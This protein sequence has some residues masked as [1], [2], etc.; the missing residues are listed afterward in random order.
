MVSFTRE[1]DYSVLSDRYNLHV[2]GLIVSYAITSNK[3]YI[4]VLCITGD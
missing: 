1:S 4:V 2:D 3:V